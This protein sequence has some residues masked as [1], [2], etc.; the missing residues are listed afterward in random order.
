METEYKMV[1][2]IPSTVLSAGTITVTVEG[3]PFSG[4][5]STTSTLVLRPNKFETEVAFKEPFDE[6]EDFLLNRFSNPP[7]KAT[8]DL[9]EETDSGRFVKTQK[10]CCLAKKWFMELRYCY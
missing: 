1:N 10:I 2:F 9:V 8:F 5:S 3:N 6:V 4:S 7:Y